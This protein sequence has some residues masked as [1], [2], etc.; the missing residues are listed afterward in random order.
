MGKDNAW[1]NQKHNN[2]FSLCFRQPGWNREIGGMT[3]FWV[4][5]LTIFK[6]PLEL[7]HARLQGGDCNSACMS[8]KGCQVVLWAARDGRNVGLAP[9]GIRRKA[10][11][12][13]GVFTQGLHEQEPCWLLSIHPFYP[14]CRP[15]RLRGESSCYRWGDRRVW[16]LSLVP[17]LLVGNRD[18]IG[19]HLFVFQQSTFLHLIFSWSSFSFIFFLLA[20]LCSMQDLSS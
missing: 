10:M 13:A 19:T 17:S 2:N 15:T 6:F 11:F 18:M 14:H 16:E 1:E 20:A 5:A 9:S 12:I 7:W 8:G 3:V 4:S